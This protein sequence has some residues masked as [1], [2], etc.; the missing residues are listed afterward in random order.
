MYIGSVTEHAGT[1]RSSGASQAPA[2]R[3]VSDNSP[4]YAPIS[5]ET[6]SWGPPSS[7][8]SPGYAPISP[9]TPSWGPPSGT[10]SPGYA[11]ISPETPS[12]GPP[13]GTDSPGYAPISP[14]TPSWGPPSGTNPPGYA[15]ISPET[16]S[17]GPPSGVIVTPPIVVLPGQ[18]HGGFCCPSTGRSANIRFLHAAVNLPAVNIRLGS[19]TVINSM[20][21]GNATPYYLHSGNQRTLITVVNAQ[22]GSTIYRAYLNISDGTAYTVSIVNEG[23]GIS[24]FTVIDTPCKTSGFGCL[25]AVNLSPNSGPVDLFL[26]GYGRVFQRIGKLSSTEYRTI[27]QGTYRTAV[28]EALPCSDNS[29]VTVANG[30]VECSNTRIAIMDSSTF[31]V[32]SGVTYTL[33]LI[34][35]AYQFPSLQILALESDLVY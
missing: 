7:A 21:Y 14:E 19:R 28:S 4:G 11:P 30:Y 35:L 23:S 17:W 10:D 31:N 15:P 27:Q 34:G 3:S 13:S 1:S 12:W 6:P 26:S 22:N 24:L 20:Q 18:N 16:P 2:Q 32:M 9:E 8:D 5:P 25:R 29:A 33:Y